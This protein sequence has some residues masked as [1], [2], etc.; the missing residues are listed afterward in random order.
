MYTS[1]SIIKLISKSDA[2]IYN[3]QNLKKKK[4]I[5]EFDK[6]VGITWALN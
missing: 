5:Q 1:L 3:R 6:G 4:T 2:Y